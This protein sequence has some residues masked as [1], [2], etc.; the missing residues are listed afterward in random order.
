LLYSFLKLPAKIALHF[1]CRKITIN[2][3]EVLQFEGPLLIAANHPNSF[4]DAIILA[5]LFKYPVYSLTRGDAFAN[6][7]YTKLLRLMNMLPVYRISEGAKNLEH[8]YSTFDACQDIFKANGIVLIFSEGRCINE[9]H[10]RPLKKGTARLALNAWQ[11]NIP[12]KVLPAGINYSC[13]RK[14]GK[15]I[16]LNFGELIDRKDFDA[17]L[18]SGKTLI[19]FNVKLNNQLK[20]LV[21]EVDKDDSVK[22]KKLFYIDIPLPKRI[23]L[24]LPSIA[25][26]LFHFPLYY[27]IAFLIWKKA[28]DHYDSILVGLLFFLYP[29]Y[30]TAITLLTFYFTKNPLSF[31]L[32]LILPFTA[33]GHLQLKKQV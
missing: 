15:N 13:F 32:P 28:E 23:F 20:Q 19:D 26:L 30:L 10:L 31:L 21:I 29:F 11:Q 9:W 17:D 6:K 12:L 18:T 8:N 1:Y 27:T 16:I 4:L 25:G 5:T 22:R 14:F 2:K 24:F 33:W 3:K 7:L